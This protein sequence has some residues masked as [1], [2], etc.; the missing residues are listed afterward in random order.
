MTVIKRIICVGLFSFLI[1]GDGHSAQLHSNGVGYDVPL[2]EL[3]DAFTKAQRE[4]DPVALTR[5]TTNDYLEVSPV[6]DV[7]TREEMLSFYAPE[8]KRVSPMI[9]ISERVVRRD[10]EEAIVVVKLSFTALGPDEATRAVAMRASFFARRTRGVWRIAAAH[11]T[12][13]RHQGS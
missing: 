6:G 12:P 1:T 10:R 5:L 8:K 7:D 11:Y 13:I 3:L 2:V 9:T 4:Y